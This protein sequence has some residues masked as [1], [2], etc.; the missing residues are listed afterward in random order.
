MPSSLLGEILKW[1]EDRP[2]WQRD[3]LRRLFTTGQITPADFEDLVALC[4]AARGLTDPRVPLVLAYDH[5]AVKDR[6]TDP[7]ALL[8]MTHH[9][10]VNALAPEQTVT[11]GT[12]L[13]IVYGP[14]T[15]GSRDTRGFSSGRVAPGSPRRYSATSLAARHLLS[16]R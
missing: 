6:G 3:A 7:V 16:H 1:S 11:F 4:K 15:A 2:G 14:N 10:G 9:C 8:S 12:N 13:T 5:L